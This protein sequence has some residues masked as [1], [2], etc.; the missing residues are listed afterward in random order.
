MQYI[1]GPVPSRRLGLSLGISPVPQK[2]CNYSCT[3]CQLGRTQHLTNRRERFFPSEAI[4]AELEQALQGKPVFDVAT[5]VGEGEPTLYSDL[6]NLIDQVKARVSQPVAVITNGALAMDSQVRSE[7][8]KADIVLISLDAYDQR[9]FQKINRPWG[10]LKFSQVFDGLKTFSREYKGQLWLEIMLIEDNAHKEALEAFKQLLANI[11]YQRL[12]LNTPVRPPAE[13]HIK[14]LGPDEM[15][16]AVAVLDGISIDLLMS[17][18]FHSEIP[19][20]YEAIMSI[21]KRHPMNQYEIKGFLQ[22]RG[23]EEPQPIFDRMERDERV[24]TIDY[25]GYTTYRAT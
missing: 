16:R 4:I 9:S 20:D 17:Q 2:T 3:Y 24:A 25:R 15:K 12:Y 13:S 11:D 22:A 23:C 6:G 19:D 8:A 5:I 18:G 10:K 7:L 21:I 1:Y 14:A